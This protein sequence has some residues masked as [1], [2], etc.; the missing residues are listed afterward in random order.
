MGSVTV[1]RRVTSSA[2]AFPPPPFNQPDPDQLH[3]AGD[4]DTVG[5]E[6]D[7]SY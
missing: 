7:V 1:T 4:L 3:Y 5:G 2:G 6:L